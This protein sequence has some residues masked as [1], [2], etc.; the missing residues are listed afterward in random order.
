MFISYDDGDHWEPLQMNLPH[1][2][3]YWHHRAGAASTIWSIATYGRGFWILDDITPLQQQTPAVRDS[4][5]HLFTPRAAYRYVS[6]EAPV[7][8]AIDM[9][10]GQNPT[11]GAPI[12]Y[13]LKSAPAGDVKVQ[14]ADASGQL[15][16]TID[17]TKRVGM[18]RVYWDPAHRT[19]EADTPSDEPAVCAGDHLQRGRLAAAARRWTHQRARRARHLYGEAGGGWPTAHATAHGSSG[20]ERRRLRDD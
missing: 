1:A 16:R 6:P 19:V 17:G 8:P 10:A 13:W 20:P 4:S 9:T 14:I 2:P 11:Y 3:V 18:N 7:S 12:N 15:L 5:I